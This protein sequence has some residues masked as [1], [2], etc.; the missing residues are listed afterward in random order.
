VW[1]AS[2]PYEHILRGTRADIADRV[3]AERLQR[4][5][6]ILVGPALGARDFGESALY[7]AGY[8]RRF[9]PAAQTDR[10]GA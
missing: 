4:T 1:R 10:N 7:S 5:A 9:R 6:I 8:D 2:W 3:R